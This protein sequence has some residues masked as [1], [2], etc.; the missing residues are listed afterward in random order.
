VVAGRFAGRQTLEPVEWFWIIL[1]GF[2]AGLSGGM[3]GIGGSTVMIPCLTVLFGPEHQHR[4]QA[5]G[6]IVTF[7]VVSA[8]LIAHRRAGAIMRGVVWR[9]APAA[10]L[11]VLVGVWISERPLF[12]DRGQV[13]LAALFGIL[14]I[15]VVLD[16]LLGVLRP[17]NSVGADAAESTPGKLGSQ[18]WLVGAASGLL[19]GL[20]GVGGG[21]IAVPLQRRFLGMPLRNAIA[22]SAAMIVAL[23]AVGA[24]YKNAA[25]V[26][27]H[28]Y[29]LSS[30]L[31]LAATLIPTAVLGSLLGSRLTHVLPVRVVHFAFTAFLALA[32]VRLVSYPLTH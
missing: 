32:A 28:G 15:F 27:T 12:A 20:T 17:R 23:S 25:L 3:L 7:F 10:T 24:V 11:C 18:P 4:H 13:Y 30:P 1:I 5:V 6:M 21:F 26:R 8:S 31:G 29:E 2:G 19:G 14:L 22:N 16:D 9:M